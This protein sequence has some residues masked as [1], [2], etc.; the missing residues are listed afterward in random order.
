MKRGDIYLTSLDPSFGH[1]QKGTRPVLVVSPDRFNEVAD[2]RFSFLHIDVDLYEPTRD[3]IAFFYPRMNVGGVIICD[4]YG[5]ATCPGATKAIDEYLRDKPE[6][7]MTLS[8]GG[9]F[10]IKGIPTSDLYRLA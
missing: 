3:S 8:D 9:G 5:F 2:R 1:E 6:K 4:D 7:M 10:L